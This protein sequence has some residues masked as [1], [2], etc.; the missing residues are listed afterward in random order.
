MPIRKQFKSVLEKLESIHGRPTP[1]EFSG[2]FEMIL[3]ENVV[4]LADD[5]KRQAAFE[6]LRAEVGLTPSRILSASLEALLV[7]T[8]LAGILPHNQVE[9][10]RRIAQI[11]QDEFAGNLSQV[12]EQPLSQAKRLLR[13]FPGIGEPGAEKI[14]LFCRVHPLFALESNGLRVLLRLGFGREQTNYAASYRSVQE[15]VQTQL[16][17]DYDWLIGAHQL[18]RRHGQEV[19]RRTRPICEVCPL[20]SLCR[21]YQG[22]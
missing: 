2:P 19:C 17:M 13:K 18:L 7:V 12:F 14:L 22:I 15:A 10:L 8:R 1:P 4:Y 16:K 5:K 11:A 21:H 3:W 20:T 6:A 9:K